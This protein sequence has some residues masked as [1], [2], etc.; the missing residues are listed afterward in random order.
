MNSQD[1][2]RPPLEC[3]A[4]HRLLWEQ[5]CQPRYAFPKLF[6]LH[7]DLNRLMMVWFSSLLKHPFGMTLWPSVPQRCRADNKLTCGTSN[8]FAKYKAKET[9]LI[10]RCSLGIRWFPRRF[11]NFDFS[12]KP[13]LLSH[14]TNVMGTFR[15]HQSVS[16]SWTQNGCFA[17]AFHKP[18]HHLQ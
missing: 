6:R 3:K 4:S 9:C 11:C 12:R 7:P 18:T 15:D 13:T 1:C 10:I 8:L 16:Q 14:P 2:W 5:H 17:M